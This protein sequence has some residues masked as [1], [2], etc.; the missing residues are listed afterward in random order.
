[1]SAQERLYGG[2]YNSQPYGPANVG[3]L[4]NGGHVI[5]FPAALQDIGVVAQAV[6]QKASDVAASATAAAGSAG[7]AS[8]SATTAGQQAGLANTARVAAEAA[9]TSVNP[10]NF[11]LKTGSTM[12]G[13]L[14]L[15]EVRMK[16]SGTGNSGTYASV[17]SKYY[18][19]D[20]YG[21]G[22][23]GWRNGVGWVEIGSI[24]QLGRALIGGSPPWTAATDGSG[25]G[26]DA[27]LLRGLAPTN[28]GL[29]NSLVARDANGGAGFAYIYIAEGGSINIGGLGS[30]AQRDANFL[31]FGKGLY[32]E[33][34]LSASAVTERSDRNLK[35]DI[36]DLE[37]SS[38]RLRPVQ[39]RLKT[40]GDLRIG[41]IAQDV[42]VAR[43]LAVFAPE[44]GPLEVRLMG[45]IAHLTLQ[46]NDALD[47]LALLEGTGQ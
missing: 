27:D 14:I 10:A 6:G 9:A 23:A 5:N 17:F 32:L 4:G 18:G 38:A 28:H 44:D 13:P 21:I 30:M 45:L 20:N 36:V 11:V 24:D 35:A 47:R 2:F 7:A 39:Y 19:D 46:L 43:P 41:F 22:F 37:P 12:T 34:A 33:G 29:P 25:S 1:M 16:A 42:A 31:G 26:L 3:G 15:P 40:T 8:A